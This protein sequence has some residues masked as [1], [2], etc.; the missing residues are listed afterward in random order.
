MNLIIDA[1]NTSTKIAFFE[2]NQ[3]IATYPHVSLQDIT[4]HI[5][6]HAPAYGIICSV[7]QDS[8]IFQQ[9]LQPFLDKVFVLDHLLPVPITNRYQTPQT[10]GKDRLAAV[11]GAT[12]LYGEYACLVIDM[13]TCIT[14]D[15][16]DA[17]K[18]YWGG[19]ISPGLQ[20]RFKAM[21][22]FTARLPL[23]EPEP[24]TVPLTGTNTI[25]AMQS[26][27]IHGMTCEIEGII[28][29]YRKN[30]SK[31]HVIFCGGDATFFENKIKESIFVIPELVLVGLNRILEYN[32]SLV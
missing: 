16:V 27:A 29:E 3:L 28:K 31:M 32:V 5:N 10:L 6:Q 20:M 23:L 15:F 2:N 7:N 30:F 13:G 12:Y 21:H 24:D 9:A 8:T 1:G 14:Y 22:T 26:G 4:T 25:E 17:Q 19:S 18:N 11:C